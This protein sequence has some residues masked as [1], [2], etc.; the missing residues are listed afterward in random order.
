MPRHKKPTKYLTSKSKPTPTT[1]T[2]SP[3]SNLKTNTVMKK[4]SFSLLAAALA[5]GVA[6]AATAYTTP[7][8]Y[9]TLS[10]PTGSTNIGVRLHESTVL[11]GVV[12]TITTPGPGSL[13]TDAAVDFDAAMP[14][15]ATF[16]IVEFENAAGILQEVVGADANNTTLAL[17]DDVS[18]FVSPGD[19]Y[20]IRKASTL[21][22]I[23]GADNSAGLAPGFG[24]PAGADLVQ[25]P[26]GLGG[27]DQYFYDG[28]ELSW[29]QV[30]DPFPTPVDASAIP[31]IYTDAFI[32]LIDAD[33]KS[34]VVTGEVKT[35]AVNHM[36]TSG[37]N[38]LSSVFPAGAT[39][40]SAFGNSS[41]LAT[42][43]AGFGGPA[44][45]DLIQILD[46]ANF[47]Q[48]FYDGDESAWYLVADPFPI[49]VDATTVNL[50][51][52]FIFANEGGPVNLLN[53]PP[54]YYSNL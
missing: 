52:G 29:Y 13:L 42:I 30:A 26:D 34:L 22:S 21:A 15:A 10:L 28:D 45:A 11:A 49:Q 5:S 16:Y 9:E 47:N 46:G 50:P 1:K 36:V 8:G 4:L 37:T 44:G 40:D 51:S 43:D 33:P 19:T 14:G 39:L 12:D 35:K 18:P 23:F 17:P 31:I 7:V 48:Y 32:V 54:S 6:S 25:I 53:T 38:Y 41:A 27:L 24:G 20:K 3:V 2:K